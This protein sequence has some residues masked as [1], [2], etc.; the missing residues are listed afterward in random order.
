MPSPT[1]FAEVKR[2]LQ[3]HG[4]TLA[5]VAGSHHIFVKPGER[6][7]SIPVHKGLVKHGYVKDA[8]ER[9]GEA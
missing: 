4:W 7:T 2:M 9:C 8:K 3:R 1:R 5:R 6:H